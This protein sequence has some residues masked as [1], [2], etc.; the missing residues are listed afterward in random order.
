M[1]I[2]TRL[3]YIRLFVPFHV[4]GGDFGATSRLDFD[5]VEW[6]VDPLCGPS[7]TVDPSWENAVGGEVV[8][9][10]GSDASLCFAL[11]N[12]VQ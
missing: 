10:A 9:G 1:F 2:H 11:L 6:Y 7:C 8:G 12:E 3:I 4:I 5:G